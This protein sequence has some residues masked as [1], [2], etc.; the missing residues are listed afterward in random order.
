MRLFQGS[1]GRRDGQMLDRYDS[2]YVPRY[3]ESLI[4]LCGKTARRGN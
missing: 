1:V 3:A 4:L 2:A